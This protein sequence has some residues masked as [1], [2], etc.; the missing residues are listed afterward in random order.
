MLE[1]MRA[2]KRESKCFMKLSGHDE[3]FE[4]E[5]IESGTFIFIFLPFTPL[6]KAQ[7]RN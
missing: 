1:W 5:T 6:E 7:T 2:K 3:A 4:R